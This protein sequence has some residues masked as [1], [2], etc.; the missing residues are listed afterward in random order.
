M[1]NKISNKKILVP[2]LIILLF[3]GLSAY[4]MRNHWL[5]IFNDSTNLS[6]LTINDIALSNNASDIDLTAYKKNPDFNNKSTEDSEYKYYQDFLIVYLRNGDISKLQTLSENGVVSFAGEEIRDLN[7]MEKKLGS[8][9][10]KQNYDSIQGLNA[11][12]YYDKEHR[13][14][15]SFVYPKNIK[16]DKEF[17][18]VILE[19]F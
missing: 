19:K 7:D 6:E 10:S 15:A 5:V 17:I 18:W 2:I 12:V 14:K 1:K 9:Y 16:N 4:Y 8:H 3:V 13:I 11:K